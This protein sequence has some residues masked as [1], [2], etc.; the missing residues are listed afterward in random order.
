MGPALTPRPWVPAPSEERVRSVAGAV[1]DLPA[2]S[3]QEEIERLAAENHR[4]H[5]VEAVNLNPAANVM[6]P[7]AE[8]LLSSGLGSRPSLGYPGDKYETGLEAIEQIEIIAAELAAQVF[9]AGHAEVRVGSGALANLYAFMAT[10][11]PGDTII[12]PPA[13]VGGHVTHHGQG[14]A[15]LYGLTTVPAPVA[16]DGY[17]VDVDALRSLAEETRPRLITVGGSLNLFPHPVPRIREIADS[18]G[19]RVLFDAAH[20]C[21]MI[22]GRTWPDPLREGAHLITMSTYKSLGGPPGGLVV[23]DDA[24]L[25]ER[26]DAIAYPGLTANSDAGRIAALAMTL[27]DWKA[28]GPAY[29]RAMTAAA[30]RLATELLTLGVPVFAAGRGCTRSHQFAVEAHRYGGGQRA[31]RRLRRANLLAC[32]I[33]LPAEPVAGDVNGLRLGT[34][35]IVRLGATEEDMPALAALVARALDPGTDPAAVA[36]EV[37]EWRSRLSGVRFTADR[38]A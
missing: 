22:A 25:A 30:R 3:V 4:I 32:G 17:T 2:A 29:A 12:A 5:D 9:G 23:T 37:T 10:C 31:A 35:E 18:V 8:A 16:A 38:P 14:A 7:R 1:A 19:A 27:L 33:G 21:G 36:P 15:G 34:P 13:S 11:G 20:L 28:A 26:L 6:N 24:E